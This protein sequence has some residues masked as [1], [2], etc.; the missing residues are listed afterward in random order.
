VPAGRTIDEQ[1]LQR[2]LRE[3]LSPYKIPAEIHCLAQLPAAPTGKVLK[4]VLRNMAQ[5]GA[6]AVPTTP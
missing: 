2:Y 1:E 3:R 6:P 5:Q 4:G